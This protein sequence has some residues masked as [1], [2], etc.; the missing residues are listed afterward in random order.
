MTQIE[1]FASR[2]RFSP[3]GC[4]LWQGGRTTAGYS[5]FRGEYGHRWSHRF[6][7]GEIPAGLEIDHLCGIRNCVNPEHL[8]AVTHR[9]NVMRSDSVSARNAAKVSCPNG[10]SYLDPDNLYI[11]AGGHRACRTCMTAYSSSARKLAYQR[12]WRKQRKAQ[13]L[14]IR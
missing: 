2:I 1:I 5:R 11:T 3:G 7:I 14:A 6:F 9:E 4:W 12:E 13:G 8:E 10:H